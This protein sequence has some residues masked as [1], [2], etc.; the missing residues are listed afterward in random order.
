M[1]GAIEL[2]LL[3]VKLSGV[4]GAGLFIA[5]SPC[6]FPLLPLFLINSLQSA[7]SR[8]RSVLVTAVLVL[9]ILSSV[10]FFIAIAGFVGSFLIE[11]YIEFQAVLGLLILFLGLVMMSSTLQMKLRLSS[12]SLRS[13]PSAPTNLLSV[14]VVGLGYSLL[15]APCSG[16]AI[17]G[18]VALFGSETNILTIVLFFI[19]LSIAIAIPYLLIAMVTGEARMRMAMTISNQARKIELIAGTILMIIGFLL[20]IQLF[21]FRFYI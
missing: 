3:L 6:L 16:P 13:Q 19:V 1:Q 5:I 7:D 11:F 17:L 9:G 8:G 15:A 20:F 21:G 18:T 2:G 12:L 10:A 14:F 4:F